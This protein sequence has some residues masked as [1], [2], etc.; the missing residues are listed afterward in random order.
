MLLSI[1]CYI[2]IGALAILFGSVIL[3][4][5]WTTIGAIGYGIMCLIGYVYN[6]IIDRRMK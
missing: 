2:A 4:A 6:K 5:A 1:A 3:A